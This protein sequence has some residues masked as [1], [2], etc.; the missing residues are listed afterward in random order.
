MKGN[1][2][3]SYSYWTLLHFFGH[4]RL[5]GSLQ[6]VRHVIFATRNFCK[7]LPNYVSGKVKIVQVMRQIFRNLEVL[8]LGGGGQYASPPVL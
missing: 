6:V 2:I 3:W 5:S 7:E 8:K 4:P 1:V